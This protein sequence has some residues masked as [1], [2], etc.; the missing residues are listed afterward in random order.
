M[1]VAVVVVFALSWLPLYIVFC[2]DKFATLS[3]EG[4]AIIFI[5]APV[6]QWLGLSNSCVNPI[7][8]AFFNDKYL[9]GFLA[10]IR[11]GSCTSRL[12]I[13]DSVRCTNTERS[14]FREGSCK[15]SI[16]RARNVSFQ[17]DDN[18]ML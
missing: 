6:A 15:E 18:V 3:K 12:R 16:K 10:I 5:A 17:G 1:L 2:L 13:E 4:Q 11:S 7:L 9:K 8:Y 14:T